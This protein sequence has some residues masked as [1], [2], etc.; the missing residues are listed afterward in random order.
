MVT[1]KRPAVGAAKGGGGGVAAKVA[2]FQ[3]RPRTTEEMER[4]A[5]QSGTSKEGFIIPDVQTFT[6][7]DGDN[8]IRILPPTWEDAGHYGDRKSVV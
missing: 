2:G 7:A 8:K 1:F 4:R 6:P 3:Y 5:H